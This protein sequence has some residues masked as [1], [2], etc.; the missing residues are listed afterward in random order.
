MADYTTV[1]T[2]KT[3]LRINGAGDDSLL[4]D[5]VTRGSRLVDDFCGRWFDARSETRLY[6][7]AGPHITGRLL[8][9]DADLLSLTAL[10]NGD[11][12]A[13]SADDVILRP[14]N[15][16]PYFGIAL[17]QESG[18]AWAYSTSPEGAI[19][20]TGEWGYSETP[21]EPV[22][23]AT[24][25]AAGWLYRLRDVRPAD[26]PLQGRERALNGL[27]SPLPHDIQSMLIPYVRMRIKCV[28]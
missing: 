5:L 18:L 24:I 8:L 22:V 23:Q 16:P 19:S 21:P 25:R 20:V 3:Y 1:S 13:I 7:A 6:D 15:W 10:S 12:T 9:L 14:V 28:A 27:F 17:R 4:A 11:G 26:W 2:L